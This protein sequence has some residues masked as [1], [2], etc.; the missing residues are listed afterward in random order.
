VSGRETG[1]LGLALTISPCW[2]QPTDMRPIASQRPTRSL[3]RVY[4]VFAGSGNG[5]PRTR[6]TIDAEGPE[7]ARGLGRVRAYRDA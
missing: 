6:A 4:V 5:R 7:A 2:L 3:A 1:G